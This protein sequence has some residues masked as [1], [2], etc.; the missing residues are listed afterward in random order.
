MGQPGNKVINRMGIS[1][2]WSYNSLIYDKRNF[3]NN[4]AI[5]KMLN[6]ILSYTHIIHNNK[7]FYNN[8]WFSIYNNK[9]TIKFKYFRK[10]IIKIKWKKEIYKYFIKRKIFYNYS[11]KIQ[12]LRYWDWLLII[13]FIYSTNF[14]S[15]KFEN[16]KNYFREKQKENSERSKKYKLIKYKK[17][18][19]NLLLIKLYF[20]YKFFYYKI[21]N[22]INLNFFLYN[23]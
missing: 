12:I 1:N 10:I 6:F 21:Y 23:F 7:Y 17:H 15:Y 11:S 18:F 5:K 14:K 2:Y 13:W 19:Y 4:Y 16:I 3:L 22:N 8:K 20:L 9:Q